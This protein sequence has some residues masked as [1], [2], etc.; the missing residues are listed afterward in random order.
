M[1][2]P[3][4]PQ[5]SDPRKIV[6]GDR[7]LTI[8]DVEDLAF[9]RAVVQLCDAP[10]YRAV[11]RASCELL[12]KELGKNA[13][14]YGVTRG[15]GDACDV[16]V[17]PELIAALP[18][19]LVR[20]HGCGTGRILDEREAAAVVAARLASLAQG[21]S[22]VRD[23]LLERL[24][25]L[26]NAR[27][28]PRIPAEGSVGASGDL[29]PL[30]YVAALLMGERDASFRGE[31]LP[32]REALERAGIPSLALK[33]KES[34]AIMNGTS[35]MT[36]LACLAYGSARRLGRLAAS[37][38]ALTSHAVHGEPT[39]FDARIFELKPH[40][41]QA[42]CARWIR[43]DLAYPGFESATR[44]ADARLQDPYS[45]R[46]APHVIGVMLDAMPWIRSTLEVELNSV[47]DNPL[48]DP[49]AG[50][51]LRGGNFYGGHVCQVMDT[52]KAA[53]AGV[54]DLHDR[55]LLLLCNPQTNNGLPSNLV[56]VAG[57]AGQ[58]HFGFKAM[59][60]SAS[61]LVAEALKL[62][63]PAAAFSRSTENH[64]QDKVSMGTIAARDCLRIL[65]LAE[66]VSII[67]LMAV[68]Q[69]VDLRGEELPAPL[70][71]LH[72]SVRSHVG[73]TVEDRAMDTDIQRLLDAYR[74]GSLSLPSVDWG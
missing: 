40:P 37:L 70:Q 19:N 65:E 24:C 73:P 23:V 52:L 41:G 66:T 67:H 30:S 29:T 61:A 46:C 38:S 51:I 31:L 48:I 49:E 9:G 26:L 32:A 42:A 57:V 72:A 25:A 17:P 71:C 22:G 62:T 16:A 27:I 63:M 20:F 45:I 58:A 50:Q 36:G 7:D 53:I 8:E 35:A 69:A 12:D 56:G 28:L 68:C 14:V 6:L 4:T 2:N 15:F 18:A 43:E 59:Q 64:N 44:P 11:L 5:A 21:K 55:Q 74:E 54:A 60:I 3:G 39:H 33:P 13:A 47:N 1:T 34:L 10:G